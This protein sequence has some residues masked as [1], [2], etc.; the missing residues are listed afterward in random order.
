MDHLSY[1]ND[2][3]DKYLVKQV[4][5]SSFIFYFEIAATRIAWI[6]HQESLSFSYSAWTGAGSSGHLRLHS[7]M[8][9]RACFKAWLLRF[10]ECIITSLQQSQTLDVEKCHKNNWVGSLSPFPP[11]PP[12]LPLTPF[13]TEHF[14][15]CSGSLLV[16]ISK[17]LPFHHHT[18]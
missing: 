2:S 12:C 18:G 14:L 16:Q 8:Q 11:L 15:T 7:E 6:V 13:L 17:I 1:C 9:I 4:N 5:K 10:Q 3:V